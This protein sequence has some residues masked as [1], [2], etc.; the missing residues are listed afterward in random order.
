M[1]RLT[2]FFLTQPDRLNFDLIYQ[3]VEGQWRL[4]GI[5]ADTTPNASSASVAEPGGSASDQPGAASDLRKMRE[6]PTPYQESGQAEQKQ[7]RSWSSRRRQRPGKP[8]GSERD[9]P[10]SETQVQC[11]SL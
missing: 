7:F 5:A 1:L 10:R 9:R 6:V 4:F 2:G 8:A 11:G 3:F